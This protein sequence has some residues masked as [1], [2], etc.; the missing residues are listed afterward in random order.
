MPLFISGKGVQV[1]PAGSRPGLTSQSELLDL[2]LGDGYFVDIRSGRPP[3]AV[4]WTNPR[5][6]ST[7]GGGEKGRLQ[8]EG[9]EG[10]KAVPA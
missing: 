4:E 9:G 6:E 8:S 7:A 5:G 1:S 10:D 2:G 3:G